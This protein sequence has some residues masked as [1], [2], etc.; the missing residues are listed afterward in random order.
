MSRLQRRGEEISKGTAGT[1]AKEPEP[2][3]DGKAIGLTTTLA[4]EITEKNVKAIV[5]LEAS[6]KQ[7][8][9][10]AD[11][12]ASGI[13]RFCGTIGFFWTHVAIF[14]G[15]IAYNLFPGV[16]RFDHYPFGFLTLV[17]S[18]EAIFLST[19]VL[20][21]QNHE[22]RLAERRA[23]LDLQINILAEQENTKLL[24]MLG[25]IAKVLEVPKDSEA[26]ALTAAIKPEHLVHQIEDAIQ[27][28]TVSD[29]GPQLGPSG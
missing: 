18:L 26:E 1:G 9:T 19:F 20:I 25:A 8:R 21:S 16:P 2:A 29:T 15:W 13:N 27:K 24:T 14:G 11:R 22:N 3:A 5:K 12:I 23:H 17:V 4:D 7:V 28:A 6:A 10:S